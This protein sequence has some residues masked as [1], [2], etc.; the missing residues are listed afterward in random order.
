MSESNPVI[1]NEFVKLKMNPDAAAI[2]K[3]NRDLDIVMQKNYKCN[4]F[5]KKDM[6]TVNKPVN[7]E[8]VAALLGLDPKAD[9]DEIKLHVRKARDRSIQ[10]LDTLN[11]DRIKMIATVRA[12]L[13]DEVLN[14]LENSTGYE[15]VN[16]KRDPHELYQFAIDIIYYKIN[17]N[18]H[19]QTTSEIV[20]DVYN[21]KQGPTEELIN[22]QHRA[23]SSMEMATRTQERH[24]K[25][26]ADVEREAENV[27]PANTVVM[28]C[29][30]RGLN[31]NYNGFK[32]DV[33]NRMQH[34]KG[35]F[36]YTD[37]NHMLNHAAEFHSITSSKGKS[38]I[39]F[40]SSMSTSTV[41][42]RCAHCKGQHYSD[43]CWK[44]FP[45]L[46]P[47]HITNKKTTTDVS[48]SESA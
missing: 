17:T 14:V 2:K 37:V 12:T 48:L 4:C 16:K 20:L 9:A 15:E 29:V 46:R 47:Q 38:M 30:L 31:D 5:T 33:S 32:M 18:A 28:Y 13:S 26:I 11:D 42:K 39:N 8:E 43:T 7:S 3:Y 10:Q 24:T 27:I 35:D 40:A 45:S 21:I 23:V 1:K 36:P 41:S 44:K 34:K 25:F 22:Y 6:A 19:I